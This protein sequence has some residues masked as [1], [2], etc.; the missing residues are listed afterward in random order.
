MRSLIQRAMYCRQHFRVPVTEKQRPVT[1]EVI[2]V[3]IA[4]NVPLT[5]PLSVIN[6]YSV[7]M[8][9]PRIV[10]NTTREL[11]RGFAR[12]FSGLPRSGSVSLHNHRIF[13]SGTTHES[14]SLL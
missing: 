4:V 14:S 12:Q 11:N 3:F 13:K 6:K 5:G 9:V 8:Q 2:D 7:R 1:T 10:S